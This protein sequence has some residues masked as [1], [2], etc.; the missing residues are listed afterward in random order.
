MVATRRSTKATSHTDLESAALSGVL[1]SATSVKAGQKHE[2]IDE[3][4]IPEKKKAKSIIEEVPNKTLESQGGQEQPHTSADEN[5]KPEETT[6]IFPT[7]VKTVPDGNPVTDAVGE[8]VTDSKT[9]QPE[10]LETHATQHI[11]QAKEAANEDHEE[12]KDREVGRDE[13]N[14]NANVVAAQNEDIDMPDIDN[15]AQSGVTISNDRNETGN[16]S[17]IIEK[18]IVSFFLPCN[19]EANK[20]EAMEEVEK[21][22]MVLQALP[23]GEKLVDGKRARL[24]VIPKTKPLAKIKGYERF[25]SSIAIT[26]TKS[27]ELEIP[28]EKTCETKQIGPHLSPALSPIPP[29]TLLPIPSPPDYGAI[30][31]PNE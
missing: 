25:L 7:D 29:K 5:S 26:N 28:R 16:A 23:D 17:A 1:K 20:P 31:R 9:E 11:T 12:R 27:Q 19:D 18:G 10:K 4:E 14:G 22:Y 15:Q 2:Q 3:V 13:L 24:I 8:S 6:N 21:L 30:L